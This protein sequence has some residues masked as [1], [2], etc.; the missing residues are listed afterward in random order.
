MKIISNKSSNWLISL[1]KPKAPE[2]EKKRPEKQKIIRNNLPQRSIENT[3]E[4]V[5]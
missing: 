2:I 3:V 4:N 1:E 5:T